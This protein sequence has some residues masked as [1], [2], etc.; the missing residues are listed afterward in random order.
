MLAGETVT[1]DGSVIQAHG[2][3][4]DFEARSNLPIWVATRG[5]K[6]LQMAGRSADGVMIATYATPR[7]IDVAASHVAMGVEARVISTEVAMTVRVDVALDDDPAA[8]RG[9]VK[10]MIAGMIKASY[11][12]TDFIEQ[13]GLE[14]PSDLH[15][16]LARTAFSDLDWVV[17]LIPETFVDAFAWAGTPEQVAEKIAV[18]VDKTGI[19]RVTYLPHSTSTNS[20]ECI[21]DRFA[22]EVMPRVASHLRG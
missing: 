12:N 20:T 4:L 18:V 8:A 6:T 10:P 2:A 16:T 19:D 11:P 5:N 22:K 7:G 21:V 3:R 1:L 17:D 13:A 15:A 9:A 14:I